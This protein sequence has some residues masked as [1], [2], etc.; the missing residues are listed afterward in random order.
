MVVYHVTTRKKLA[1]FLAVGYILPPVRAW[2]SILSA[3]RFSKQTSRRIILRLK[4]PA[5]APTLAGHRGEAV[6]L[7][8]KFYL[9]DM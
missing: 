3:E 7:D 4:F 5:D 8:E 6:V 1:K 2:K 9:K